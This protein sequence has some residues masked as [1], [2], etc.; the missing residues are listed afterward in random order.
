MCVSFNNENYWLY[1]VERYFY[2]IQDT[3]L[4][5]LIIVLSKYSSVL[6]W[7]PLTYFFLAFSWS[8]QNNEETTILFTIY[9][10]DYN[11][12]VLKKFI[13]Y[14]GKSDFKR[15]PDQGK[16]GYSETDLKKVQKLKYYPW[17]N[18]QPCVVFTLGDDE[19][20]V[21]SIFIP[22]IDCITYSVCEF[23][24]VTVMTATA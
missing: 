12:T 14:E 8:Y 13:P 16:P 5:F 7:R 4:M 19:D 2:H 22:S 23:L 24:G 20:T 21:T 1:T 3:D 18:S 9:I 15:Q 17:K 11:G 6:K 10:V